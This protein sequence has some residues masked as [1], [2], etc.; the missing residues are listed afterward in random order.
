[1]SASGEYQGT[2]NRASSEAG[3]GPASQLN[4]SAVSDSPEGDARQRKRRRVT[5]TRLGCFTCRKRR[6]RCDM[7]KPECCTCQRLKLVSV[8]DG[9]LR[10]LTLSRLA[11]THVLVFSTCGRLGMGLI[12]Y[13]TIVPPLIKGCRILPLRQES[14]LLRLWTIL[15]ISL[16]SCL[17]T[18][19]WPH[20]P[21][22]LW[23][24]RHT[25]IL[26]VLGPSTGKSMRCDKLELDTASIIDEH[27]RLLYKL[28]LQT[29]STSLRAKQ[30]L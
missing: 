19:T 14:H 13:E 17:A 8:Y 1:M 27:N 18:M 12:S 11:S 21:C 7:T 22:G 4:R 9:C 16:A 24:R 5:R 30:L 10:G 3:P 29:A 23:L 26:E 6:K 28:G 25:W 15:C 2:L 20:R